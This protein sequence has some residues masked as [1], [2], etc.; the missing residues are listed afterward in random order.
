MP[1]TELKQGVEMMNGQGMRGIQ[2][3]MCSHRSTY[4]GQEHSGGRKRRKTLSVNDGI[5]EEINKGSDLSSI[6][7]V[8]TGLSGRQ[9]ARK[10]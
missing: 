6:L 10:F 9:C 5:F 8:N 4:K 7:K 3:K 2:T 1:G